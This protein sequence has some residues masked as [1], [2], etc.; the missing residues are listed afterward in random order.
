MI[1]NITAGVAALLIG[2]VA[3]AALFYLPSRDPYA[4]FRVE[5]LPAVADSTSGQVSEESSSEPAAESAAP[6]SGTSTPEISAG[7]GG[8]EGAGASSSLEGAD[9]AAL[10]AEITA[11]QTQFGRLFA[12]M[13]P[14]QAVAILE[15]LSDDVARGVLAQVPARTAAAIL[16]ELP[17][18]RAARIAGP[19]LPTLTLPQSHQ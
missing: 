15:H 1:R 6:E 7:G 8:L 4:I 16:A 19:Y 2:F 9:P 10:A 14:A 5:H 17:A 11:R 18:E 12:T 13:D 3:M